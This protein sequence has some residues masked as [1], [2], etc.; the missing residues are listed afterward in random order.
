MKRDQKQFIKT[1]IEKNGFMTMYP[2]NRCHIWWSYPLK[3]DQKILKGSR[4]FFEPIESG[5]FAGRLVPK[6]KI[7]IAPPAHGGIASHEDNQKIL[8]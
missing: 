5:Y 2:D 7:F 4:L 3:Y 6:S 8:I 1:G